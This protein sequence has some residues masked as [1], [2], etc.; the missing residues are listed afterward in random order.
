MKRNLLGSSILLGTSIMSAL[1]IPWVHPV[2]TTFELASVSQVANVMYLERMIRPIES[3]QSVFFQSLAV[4]CQSLCVAPLDHQAAGGQLRRV[5]QM[6]TVKLVKHLSNAKPLIDCQLLRCPENLMCPREIGMVTDDD[7][8]YCC[9]LD[10]F[11]APLHERADAL[12]VIAGAPRRICVKSIM[13]SP[14]D[15]RKGISHVIKLGVDLIRHPEIAREMVHRIDDPLVEVENSGV[16]WLPF[17]LL[18]IRQVRH[19]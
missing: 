11:D 12:A 17:N 5:I 8:P 16:F 9:R 13:P 2:V 1:L 14:M 15:L 4:I 10:P 19:R 3:F 18:L 7:E 6:V